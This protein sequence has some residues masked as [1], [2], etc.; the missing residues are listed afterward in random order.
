MEIVE[1]EMLREQTVLIRLEVLCAIA[2]EALKMN[3]FAQ[4]SIKVD[5]MFIMIIK[6]KLKKLYPKQFLF[7]LKKSFF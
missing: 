3:L 6:V 1:K 4:V 5:L 7:L 2:T